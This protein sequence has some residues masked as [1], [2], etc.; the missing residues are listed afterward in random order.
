MQ[1]GEEELTEYRS[2]HGCNTQAGSR[3]FDKNKKNKIKAIKTT[4]IQKKKTTEA[5][6]LPTPLCYSARVGN[7]T[8]GGLLWLFRLQAAR[9]KKIV[10]LK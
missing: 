6:Q 1:V 5:S 4:V 7:I 3:N 2:G 8:V 9:Q 10:E